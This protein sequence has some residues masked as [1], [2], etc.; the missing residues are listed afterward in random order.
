[1]PLFYV[2]E[3][4][5][6]VAIWRLIVDEP[7]TVLVSI[8]LVVDVILIYVAMQIVVGGKEANNYTATQAPDIYKPWL[9]RRSPEN[10]CRSRICFVGKQ[11][12]K[13]NCGTESV[14]V[15]RY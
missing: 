13:G 11:R 3:H 15:H 8:S 4:N 9:I 6:N 1:M 5:E 2:N 7:I 12:S 14:F 10:Y